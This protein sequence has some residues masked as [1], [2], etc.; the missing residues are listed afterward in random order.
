MSIFQE[1]SILDD[2]CFF[3]GTSPKKSL[4]SV[5][6]IKI[7]KRPPRFHQSRL[8]EVISNQPI[9][10]HTTDYFQSQNFSKNTKFLLDI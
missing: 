10:E 4:V 9:W 2:I 1:R 5:S 3:G 7:W 8:E 6:K